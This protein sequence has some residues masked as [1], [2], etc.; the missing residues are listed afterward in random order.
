MKRSTENYLL[1][2]YYWNRSNTMGAAASVHAV[3][4]ESGVWF[5]EVQTIIYL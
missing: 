1:N 3:Y 2:K 5:R 4:A